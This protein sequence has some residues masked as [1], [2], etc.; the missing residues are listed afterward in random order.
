M[1]VEEY[2]FL[3]KCLQIHMVVGAKNSRRPF[4]ELH[5]K[6][7]IWRHFLVFWCTTEEEHAFSGVPM[8]RRIRV[9][10]DDSSGS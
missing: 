4:D 1:D 6:W 2:K 3:T 7:W 8:E 10:S 9:E 5:V